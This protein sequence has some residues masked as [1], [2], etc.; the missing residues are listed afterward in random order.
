MNTIDPLLFVEIITT[1]GAEPIY[2]SNEFNLEVQA[3]IGLNKK[4]V[5]VSIDCDISKAVA[6]GYLNQLGMT[7]ITEAL[8]PE[9]D[10]ENTLPSIGENG[11]NNESQAAEE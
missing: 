5:L 1:E 6:I 4:K 3:F 11:E 10:I 9:G 8:F 7:D 2:N